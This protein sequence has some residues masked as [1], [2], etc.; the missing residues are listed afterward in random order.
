MPGDY[1]GD[2]LTDLAVF[3]T[4]TGTWTVRGYAPVVFG[5]GTD[6]PVPGDYDGDGTTDIAVYTPATST[7]AVRNQF[8]IVFGDPGDVPVVRIGTTVDEPTAPLVT[9]HPSN[10]TV[11]AGRTA[12]FVAMASG[13]PWPRVQWQVRANGGGSWATSLAPRPRR[14]RSRPRSRTPAN[15]IARCSPTSRAPRRTNSASLTV[16]SVSGSDFDGDGTTDM[17]VY[18]QADGF[19][20][21]GT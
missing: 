14:M 12:S 3:D 10:Q 19:W 4:S 11:K 9:T 13:T 21:R 1:N 2:G 17:V 18:R 7:W 8:T 16:R 20:Y 6:T 5:A 15:S